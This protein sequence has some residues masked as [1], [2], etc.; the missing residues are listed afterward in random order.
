MHGST[1]LPINCVIAIRRIGDCGAK[2]EEGWFGKAKRVC[3]YSA[4]ADL[5]VFSVF[6]T[7]VN[8]WH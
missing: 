8:A 2:R 6:I 5:H 7:S 1:D 4:L 3:G